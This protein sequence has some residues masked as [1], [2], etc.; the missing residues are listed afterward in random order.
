MFDVNET[1]DHGEL[2]CFVRQTE[3]MAAEPEPLDDFDDSVWKRLVTEIEIDAAI[4]ELPENED[5]PARQ[6]QRLRSERPTEPEEDLSKLV[7]GSAR[8]RRRIAIVQHAKRL[9]EG[10]DRIADLITHAESLSPP[11]AAVLRA[12]V[13]AGEL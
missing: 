6:F 11:I 4:R 2:I 3:R 12:A 8:E 5:K 9:V 7:P 10:G 1:A 13:A